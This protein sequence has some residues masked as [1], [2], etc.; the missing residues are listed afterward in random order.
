MNGYLIRKVRV[1]HAGN[2]PKAK[3]DNVAHISFLHPL[4]FNDEIDVEELKVIL[5]DCFEDIFSPGCI[6][7]FDI[8]GNSI[9]DNSE[10]K[11]N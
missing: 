4:I 5:L 10:F 1:L 11:I 2:P 9:P 6:V 7:S 3:K 8:E